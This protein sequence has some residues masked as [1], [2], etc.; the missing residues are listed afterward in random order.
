MVILREHVGLHINSEF[1]NTE[2][3]FEWFL[4]FFRGCMF[5]QKLREETLPTVYFLSCH[6]IRLSLHKY[7]GLKIMINNDLFIHIAKI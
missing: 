1:R 2:N 3:N 4:D 7:R 6:N 5:V